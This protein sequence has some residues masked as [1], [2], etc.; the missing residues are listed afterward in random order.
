MKYIDEL[1][2]MARNN[3]TKWNE[4]V[5]NINHQLIQILGS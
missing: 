1:T 4:V 5:V 3:V 2:D